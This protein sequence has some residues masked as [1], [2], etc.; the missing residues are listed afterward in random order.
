MEKFKLSRW[1]WI[2]R[3]GSALAVL[4][5]LAG[6]GAAPGALAAVRTI[7][8]DDVVAP[9]LFADTTPLTTQYAAQGVTFSGPAAGQGG[10]ILNESGSFGVIRSQLS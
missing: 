7:N 2:V 10:A 6:L 1:S 3:F 5:V 8:F 4:G 9:A